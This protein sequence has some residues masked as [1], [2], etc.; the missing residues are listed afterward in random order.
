MIKW[1][2]MALKTFKPIVKD[3]NRQE[4][5]GIFGNQNRDE[6]L[7]KRSKDISAFRKKVVKLIIATVAMIFISCLYARNYFTRVA[8]DFLD[9]YYEDKN[10]T[11]HT[12]PWRDYSS[13][14]FSEGSF[15]GSI[16]NTSI[17]GEVKFDPSTNT[18]NYNVM[19]NEGTSVEGSIPVTELPPDFNSMNASFN[20]K[21]SGDNMPIPMPE[22]WIE[23]VFNSSTPSFRGEDNWNWDDRRNHD[24]RDRHHRGG[25]NTQIDFDLDSVSKEDAK[26][27]AHVFINYA[28][29]AVFIY[30]AGIF[31]CVSACCLCAIK[32]VKINQKMREAYIQNG[33]A[34]I[35]FSQIP[36]VNM[37]H[38]QPV[39]A[40]GFQQVPNTEENDISTQNIIPR[41]VVVNQIN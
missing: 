4:L 24:R 15:N 20:F 31:L 3:L 33:Q 32:K 38:Q 39:N 13:S 25:H 11:T 17:S 6:V 37:V 26:D 28:V 9:S 40:H 10:T 5:A 21:F 1:G 27:F 35:Q 7:V 16:G 30:S 14:S 18:V 34:E 8:D 29:I 23:D 19:S 2:F 22:P 41:G 12:L 36:P